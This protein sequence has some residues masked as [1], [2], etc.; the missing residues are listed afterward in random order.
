[1]ATSFDQLVNDVLLTLYGYGLNQPRASFLTQPIGASDLTIQVRDASNFSQ[2]VAEIGDELVFI[3]SVDTVGGTLTLSP[4]G[5]GYFN[6]TGAAHDANARIECAPVW[7]KQRVRAAINDAI[8]GTYP[9]LWATGTESFTWNPS[10]NTYALDASAERVLSVTTDTIGPSGEQVAINKYA[11]NSVGPDGNII[12]LF[13]A[14]WPGRDVTVTYAKAPTTVASGDDFTDSGLRES[15]LLAIK[16]A[17]CSTL[18]AFMDT[19]R[20]A[21]D[22]AQAD[23]YDPSKAGIGTAARLSVQ[24]YPRYQL[25]LSNERKRLMATTPT[26]ITLRKR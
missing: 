22:T 4:D 2:G 5:R 18:L 12:T 15:A 10:V 6:T 20:L 1:M 23:E 8:V 26:P 9:T 3:D 14:G 24:L 16:Y 13:E 19:A 11:F 17:A 7:P 21:V 25:E